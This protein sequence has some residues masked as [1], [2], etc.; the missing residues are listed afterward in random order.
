MSQQA[1]AEKCPLPAE[2]GTA[3]RGGT[4][5]SRR[6]RP[7]GSLPAPPTATQTCPPAGA[8]P[9]RPGPSRSPQSAARTPRHSRPGPPKTPQAGRPP[10]RPRTPTCPGSSSRRQLLR[11]PPASAAALAL[12]GRLLPHAATGNGRAER[13]CVLHWHGGGAGRYLGNSFA[14]GSRPAP[15]GAYRQPGRS[16]QYQPASDGQSRG[17]SPPLLGA[18]GPIFPCGPELAAGWW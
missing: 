7:R 16:F 12:A 10:A 14:L 9:A 2:L 18:P 3:G 4:E 11:R 1:A 6:W 13:C 8:P 5:T 17:A 15:F